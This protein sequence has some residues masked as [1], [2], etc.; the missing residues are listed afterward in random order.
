MVIGN[1]HNTN[2]GTNTGYNNRPN[3][4]YG[5]NTG[6]NTGYNNVKPKTNYGTNTGY[7]GR[8]HPNY[9]NY[10]NQY[11]RYGKLLLNNC[12][13]EPINKWFNNDE[14]LFGTQN[15]TPSHKLTAYVLR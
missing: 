5:T 9:Q 7:Y 10:A 11:G 2:Y 1:I 12:N 13:S 6:Y 4:N 8:T 14:T 3:T 15:P